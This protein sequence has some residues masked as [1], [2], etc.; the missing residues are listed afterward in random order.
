M[1]SAE[2]LDSTLNESLAIGLLTYIAL[3]GERATTELFDFGEGLFSR[4]CDF[5]DVKQVA[6]DH[7]ATGPRKL[8]GDTPADSP[9]GPRDEGDLAF[10]FHN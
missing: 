3:D 4:R 1:E 2:L 8:R 10:E 5:A 9:S 7:I 6:D